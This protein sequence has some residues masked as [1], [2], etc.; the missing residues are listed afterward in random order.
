MD[1]TLQQAPTT[2]P[3]GGE[4]ALLAPAPGLLRPPPPECPV[5]S[6][7]AS[8]SAPLTSWESRRRAISR[9]FQFLENKQPTSSVPNTCNQT[10]S[11]SGEKGAAES[12]LITKENWH[13]FL[14]VCTHMC[15]L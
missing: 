7:W 1:S 14:H 10:Q 6:P 9:T 2:S 8:S 4:G 3:A 13:F 12:P 15:V 5:L 11:L